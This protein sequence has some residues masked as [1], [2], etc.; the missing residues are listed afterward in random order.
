MMSGGWRPSEGEPQHRRA[1]L[2]VA[3][4]LIVNFGFAAVG[5][6]PETV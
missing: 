2:D 1:I 6:T 3:T 4:A 5:L